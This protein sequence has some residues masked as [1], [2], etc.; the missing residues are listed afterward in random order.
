MLVG[1]GVAG[2]S[3]CR[4]LQTREI[5]NASCASFMQMYA[6]YVGHMETFKYKKEKQQ[7]SKNKKKRKQQQQIKTTFFFLIC[8]NPRSCRIVVLSNYEITAKAALSLEF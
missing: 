3:F 8:R 2:V 1:G 4:D 7:K 5:V 6:N